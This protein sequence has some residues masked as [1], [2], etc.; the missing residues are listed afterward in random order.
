MYKTGNQHESYVI[1]TSLL[2]RILFDVTGAS[3]GAG[4]ACAPPVI[5]RSVNPISTRWADYAHLF[6]TCP[7][8]F[9]YLATAL[10]DWTKGTQICIRLEK[11]NLEI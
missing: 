10:R 11:T 7:S 2:V 9:S 1:G 5:G 4:G 6:T 3:G 8:G